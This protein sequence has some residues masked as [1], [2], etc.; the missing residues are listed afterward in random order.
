MYTC[1][2]LLNCVENITITFSPF[3]WEFVISH[4]WPHKSTCWASR[5]SPLTKK[6]QRARSWGGVG[7]RNF[8]PSPE[9]RVQRVVSSGLG[10]RQHT[11]N[12]PPKDLAFSPDAFCFVRLSAA[13]W[14]NIV[15]A[16]R[17]VPCTKAKQSVCD[18][19][20]FVKFGQDPLVLCGWCQ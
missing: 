20:A 19:C 10:R 6:T 15:S 13:K 8:S 5:I 2:P 9:M 1:L 7:V 4:I 3:L 12:N 11:L 14:R 16:E 18:K 17:Q